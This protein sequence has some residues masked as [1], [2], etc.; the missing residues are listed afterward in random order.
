MFR[1]NVWEKLTRLRRLDRLE[2]EKLE[3][4]R[5]RDDDEVLAE[6]V[7]GPTGVKMLA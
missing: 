1:P 6:V 7:P 5:I 2:G 4:I 3:V